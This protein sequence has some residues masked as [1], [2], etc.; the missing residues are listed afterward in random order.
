MLIVVVKRQRGSLRKAQ[1]K[2]KGQTFVS[3]KVI[4]IIFKLKQS[5]PTLSTTHKAT[6][7]K[8]INPSPKYV[9]SLCTVW[10]IH[11]NG[12]SNQNG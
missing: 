5:H 10:S 6:Q 7:Q 8:M 2:Y 3:C 1:T 9:Q 11:Y 4:N 12:K